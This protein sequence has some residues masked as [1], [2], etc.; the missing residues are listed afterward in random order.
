V[1]GVEVV[2]GEQ[3]EREAESDDGRDPGR[4]WNGF[5]EPLDCRAD[6]GEPGTIRRA[7]SLHRA[8]RRV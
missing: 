5:I 7:S 1:G 4:F 3:A 8:T 2:R 6:A